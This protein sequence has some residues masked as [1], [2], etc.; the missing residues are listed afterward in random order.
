MTST[1]TELEIKMAEAERRTAKALRELLMPDGAEAYY[2]SF[3]S[4]FG[5]A[6]QDDDE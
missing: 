3:C 5:L 1:A 4:R 2:R 6:P